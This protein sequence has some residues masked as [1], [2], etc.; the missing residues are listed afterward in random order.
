MTKEEAIELAWYMNQVGLQI[1]NLLEEDELIGALKVCDYLNDKID[2]IKRYCLG[3]EDTDEKRMS[4]LRNEIIPKEEA[5]R[6]LHDIRKTNMTNNE[7]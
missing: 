5:E 7:R 3:I 4:D 6:L 2:Q 1:T